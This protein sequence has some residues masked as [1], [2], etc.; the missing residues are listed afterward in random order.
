MKAEARWWSV[1]VALGACQSALDAVTKFRTAE[2]AW[3]GTVNREW[4][5]WVVEALWVKNKI[6]LIQV[7]HS[8]I[9]ICDEGCGYPECYTLARWKRE[10]RVRVLRAVEKMRRTL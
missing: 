3:D 5:R 8:T 6:E 2:A 7:D 9:R 1:L 10:Y 4:L